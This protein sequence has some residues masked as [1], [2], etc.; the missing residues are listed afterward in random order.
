MAIMA[1]VSAIG[2]MS[3]YR[4][5]TIFQLRSSADE[6]RSLMQYGRELAITNKDQGSYDITY[7]NKV[8]RLK[9][10]S[11]EM[12]R[13]TIPSRMTV[14]P[15]SLFW[16]YSPLTGNIPNCSPCDITL[17]FNGEDEVITIQEN[18]LVN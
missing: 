10:D 5:Q 7:T 14:I 1:V 18:G 8:F 4:L 11:N 13:V 9:V 3:Y 6:I 16:R 15:A 17:T 2:V 12:Y